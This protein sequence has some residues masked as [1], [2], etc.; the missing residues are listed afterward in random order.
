LEAALGR[1]LKHLADVCVAVEGDP[2]A[3]ALIRHLQQNGYTAQT[4]IEQEATGRIATVR[5]APDTGD[6]GTVL[7][8]LFASSGIEAEVVATAEVIGLAGSLRAPVATVS[9]LIALKVLSRDD[10]RRPQDRVD[11]VAL[12]GV[13]TAEDLDEARRFLRLIAERGYARGRN[14]LERLT[15][16]EVELV[17]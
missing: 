15:E 17:D 5:L 8:L 12:I 16:L 14:L 4:L 6:D 2:E 10:T 3:E 7:D 13:A 9:A 11:L 1:V